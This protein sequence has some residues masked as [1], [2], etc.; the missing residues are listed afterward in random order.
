MGYVLQHKLLTD[1]FFQRLG[2]ANVSPLKLRLPTG[3]TWLV[4]GE[5]G[6]L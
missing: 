4:V 1:S 2:G 3:E 6:I 5:Y